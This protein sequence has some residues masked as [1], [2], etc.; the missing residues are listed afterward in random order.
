MEDKTLENPHKLILESRDRL[1]V[2]GVTE[3][4][5]FDEAMVVLH[6][7]KG[8]LVVRGEGLHLQMLSLDGGQVHVDGNVNS[9]TYEELQQGSFLS[10]L[11]G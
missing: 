10:R 9:M 1:T 4:E 5:S 2:N 3:V 7:T 8:V 6:T 11:F